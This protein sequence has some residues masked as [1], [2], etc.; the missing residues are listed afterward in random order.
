VGFYVLSE[1]QRE[2]RKY[3]IDDEIRESEDGGK[4]HS[5]FGSLKDDRPTF[6]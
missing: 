1:G 2:K 3:W 6:L 5:L 4:F